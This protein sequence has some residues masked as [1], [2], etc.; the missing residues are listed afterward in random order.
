MS[1]GDHGSFE[2]NLVS[3]TA[4]IAANAAVSSFMPLN[5]LVPLALQ[6]PTPFTSSNIN[7]S[8]SVDGGATYKPIHVSGA[9]YSMNI[10]ANSINPLEPK[11]FIG[12]DAIK[13]NTGSNE[14]GARDLVLNIGPVLALKGN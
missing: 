11:Y 10:A 3:K 13:V 5:G 12:L 6:I 9:L 14:N 8:G 4:T 2:P 7:F 1:T